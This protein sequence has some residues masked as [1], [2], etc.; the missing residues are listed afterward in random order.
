MAMI[1]ATCVCGTSLH[2]QSAGSGQSD[3]TNNSS[4]VMPDRISRREAEFAEL[5]T[6]I[7]QLQPAVIASVGAERSE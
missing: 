5:K 2:A 3:S 6:M 4:Q 7:K 1:V